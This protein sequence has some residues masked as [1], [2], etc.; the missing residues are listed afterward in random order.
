MVRILAIGDFHGKFPEK[1]KKEAEKV[2]F[3]LSTGDFGGSDRLLKIIFKYFYTDWTKVVGTKKAKELILEDY[4]SGKFILNKLGKLKTKVYTIHGNWDFEERKHKKR[5]GGLKLKKYSEIMRTKKNIFFLNKKLINIQGLKLYGFGGMVT[6]SIY[7]TRES[8]FDYKK[9]MRQR[10]M[11]NLEKKQLFKNAEKNIDILLAHYPPYGFFDIVKYKGE[12]PM[13]GKHVGFKPYTEFI[14]KYQPRLF[15]C[16]HM[17]EYQGI[18]KLGNT[19]IIAT[20]S[21]KEGK[22]AIIEYPDNKK[23]K[24]SVKFLN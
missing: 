21:T 19:L 10:R 13:N 5:T 8:G 24:I 4:N 14:K 6:S 11:H 20:G 2:D 12:N 23:G 7:L 15:I 9:Q 3:V 17:H 22:A 18:K 1:L 16:G